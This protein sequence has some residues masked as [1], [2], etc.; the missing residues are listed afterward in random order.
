MNI[1][2]IGIYKVGYGFSVF[3]SSHYEFWVRIPNSKTKICKIIHN[4]LVA[5]L[6]EQ[7]AVCHYSIAAMGQ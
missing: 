5:Q 2:K 3:P 7:N 4:A 6:G 1:K